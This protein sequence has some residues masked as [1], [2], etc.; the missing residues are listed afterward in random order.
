MDR[1]ASFAEL[2]AGEPDGSFEIAHEERLESRVIVIAPHGGQIEVHT[3]EIARRIA[4]TDFSY[5][6]FAGSKQKNNRDLHITSH[7]FDEPTGIALVAEHRWVL[8]VHGCSGDSPEVLLGGLDLS[9]KTAIASQLQARGIEV[10]TEHHR[11]P[12]RHPSNI[13]NRG[14]RRRGVQLELSMPFRASA[15]VTGLVIAVREVL[16]ERSNGLFG[17]ACDQGLKT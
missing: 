15:A 3:S 5:Y 4:G 17:R 12:G 7:R 1:Y 2:R 14:S 11:Y 10:R 6:S 8:A 13:C 9:L 16:L